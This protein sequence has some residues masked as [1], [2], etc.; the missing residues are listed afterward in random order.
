MKV[1]RDA[2]FIISNQ[3]PKDE[4]KEISSFLKAHGGKITT[5]VSKKAH[6]LIRRF[7]FILILNRW[8]D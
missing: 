6:F 5:R 2:I 8:R 7:F 4:L 1:W 3:T